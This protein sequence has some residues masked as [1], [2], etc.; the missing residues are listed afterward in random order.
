MIRNKL[1]ALSLV[2]FFCPIPILAQSQPLTA[3]KLKQQINSLRAE[4]NQLHKKTA[5]QLKIKNQK[6]KLEQLIK[7]LAAVEKAQLQK[8]RLRAEK[9]AAQHKGGALNNNGS[10]EGLEEPAAAV[11]SLKQ[12][13]W[14]GEAGIIA[15]MFGG[16]TGI[17]GELRLPLRYVFG[18]ATTSYRVGGGLTQNA[19]DNRRYVT[20]DFDGI[21]NYP[22]GWLSGVDNYL[23]AGINYVVLTSGRIAGTFGGEVFYGVES[24]GFGGKLF[25]ELGYGILRSGVSPS[26][27]GTTVLLGYRAGWQ[28]F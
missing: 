16:A 14:R 20:V 25:A 10:L 8:Q 12:P 24:R 11:A 23:G 21:I 4:I 6:A 22:A 18:P 15:G 17:F 26:L 9:F 1:I 3:D 19:D 2:F 5:N 28:I 13:R 27:K 7:Q